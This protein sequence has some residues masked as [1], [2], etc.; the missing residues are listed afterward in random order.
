MPDSTPRPLRFGIQLQAQRTTWPEYR[1]AVTVVEDLG[2]DAVWNFDHMLPFSG[3]D[4]GACFETFTT[5]AAMASLTSH[6]RIGSL[7]NGVLYRDPATLAK[8][9]AMVDQI[10]DGRLEF[11]LG[12]AW[13]EREFGAYGLPFPP[14]GERMERLDEALTI[15]KSLWTQPRTTFAGRYYQIHDAPCEPKPVQ[16]PYPPIMIGGSGRRTIGIAAKHANVWN[17]IGSP[18]FCAERIAVLHAACAKIGRDP[19]E[20]ELTVHPTLAI[21]ATH[22]EAE[23]KARAIA[24]SHGNNLDDERAGWLLGTPDEIREQVQRYVDIGMTQWMMALGAPF[25]RDMLRLFANEVM[26]V[27]R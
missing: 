5:L 8:S 24:A 25:D 1:D 12:A 22:D 15:V 4:D 7:V 27:F 21:A 20:I 19:A 9:A 23:T 3:A 14:V 16:R 10:S 11:T 17:C 18:E 13:A 2:Y 6:V 26:P